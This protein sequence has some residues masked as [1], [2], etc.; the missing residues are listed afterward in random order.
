MNPEQI[1]MQV[2]SLVSSHMAYTDLDEYLKCCQA[3]FD[4]VYDGKLWSKTDGSGAQDG[5]GL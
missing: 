3:V 4:W 5:Q 1:R 2:A